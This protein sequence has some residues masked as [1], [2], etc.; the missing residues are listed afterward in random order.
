[1][2]EQE[3]RINLFKGI[4]FYLMMLLLVMEIFFPT[5]LQNLIMKMM[6]WQSQGIMMANDNLR[7]LRTLAIILTIV[8]LIRVLRS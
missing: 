2:K 1:M 8:A 4:M 7:T 3:K 5:Q 6:H